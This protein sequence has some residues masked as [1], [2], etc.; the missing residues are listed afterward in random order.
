MDLFIEVVNITYVLIQ[1][2]SFFPL[3]LVVYVII[4]TFGW[5]NNVT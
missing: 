2:M 4:C 5:G 1:D 3:Q